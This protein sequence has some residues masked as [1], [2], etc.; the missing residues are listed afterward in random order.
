MESTKQLENKMNNEQ[1][2]VPEIFQDAFSRIKELK[3]RKEGTEIKL[4]PFQA[5]TINDLANE[6]SNILTVVPTGLGKSLCFQIPG[7]TWGK[8]LILSPLS[9]LIKDQIDDLN[10]IENWIADELNVQ[11]LSKLINE[12]LSFI[13]GSPE[14]LNRIVEHNTIEIQEKLQSLKLIVIDEAHCISSWGATFRPDYLIAIKSLLAIINEIPDETQRPK[15]LGLTATVD[16]FTQLDIRD[17]F[18]YKLIRG[19]DE[20]HRKQN[21]YFYFDDIAKPDSPDSRTYESRTFVQLLKIL[22]RRKGDKGLIFCNRVGVANT[23]YARLRFLNY[24]IRPYHARLSRIEKMDSML[25]FREEDDA[26]LVCT[27][28]FGMGL[29]IPNIK[30]TIHF[31]LPYDSLDYKQE[32]GRAGRGKSIDET[33]SYVIYNQVDLS[34]NQRRIES[35]QQIQDKAYSGFGAYKQYKSLILAILNKNA[36]AVRNDQEGKDEN[37]AEYIDAGKKRITYR[38]LSY[39]IGT[40]GNVYLSGMIHLGIIEKKKE[41]VYYNKDHNVTPDIENKYFRRIRKKATSR[42][43][44]LMKLAKEHEV[45][46]DEY[47]H[48]PLV[49][50]FYFDT[51]I[52]YVEKYEQGWDEMQYSVYGYNEDVSLEQLTTYSEIYNNLNHVDLVIS[53]TEDDNKIL[54]RLKARIPNLENAE[55]KKSFGTI[56]DRG[57]IGSV[58]IVKSKYQDYSQM[59]NSAK[60]L[61]ENNFNERAKIIFIIQSKPKIID[62]RT[63]ESNIEI[64]HPLY[65]KLAK[66]TDSYENIVNFLVQFLNWPK[67]YNGYYTG[68]L[69]GKWSHKSLLLQ[70]Y[71]AMPYKLLQRWCTS[72]TL[73]EI[74]RFLKGDENNQ[75]FIEIKE[76]DQE[77]QMCEYWR[78]DTFEI[79]KYAK[80]YRSKMLKY[81]ANLEKI[82]EKKGQ[83]YI[84][85]KL[86]EVDKSVNKHSISN[87]FKYFREYPENATGFKYLDKHYD[88]INEIAEKIDL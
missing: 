32:I 39:L 34:N 22:E 14:S 64:I 19:K 27:N 12:D 51:S 54:E 45:P 83:A 38:G 63:W 20:V 40:D 48:N 67:V 9:Q 11:N 75:R 57:N 30:Y 66:R 72:S 74:K 87:L 4:R 77:L 50:G 42:F 55:V 31:Y 60:L 78:Y 35:L 58:L 7:L 46:L 88:L 53:E 5:E 28:A 21:Y 33:D 13:C 82:R 15:I 61:R 18:R 68:T 3:L 85:D 84:V 69:S 6:T 26:I 41:Y 36:Q 86:N 23:L 65:I 24:N 16:K 73:A 25:W 17:V 29:N 52:L 47:D 44:E 8:T 43:S 1:F 79:S 37:S 80:E 70:G 2:E 49:T 10:E 76:S 81:F 56:I 59:L 62:Y 71:I